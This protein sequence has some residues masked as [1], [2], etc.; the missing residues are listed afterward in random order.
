[1]RYLDRLIRWV[2]FYSK[3]EWIFVG[4]IAALVGLLYL[5]WAYQYISER[6]Q[7]VS[8]GVS[9]VGKVTSHTAPG[10]RS[11]SIHAVVVYTVDAK[12]YSIE[13]EGCYAGPNH[14]A[15]GTPVTVWFVPGKP[16]V[17]WAKAN[18]ATNRE[19]SDRSWANNVLA[20]IVLV[21][22]IAIWRQYLEKPAP[23]V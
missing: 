23:R 17:A 4:S 10:K 21:I 9:T 22:G 15:V 14:L 5:P 7:I 13:L 16:W 6:E 8:E 20:F 18:N 2:T 11:C 1:M 3:I 12:S 19:W